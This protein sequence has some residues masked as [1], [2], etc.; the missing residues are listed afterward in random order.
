VARRGLPW[1]TY[2]ILQGLSG[3]GFEA[4]AE[5][6]RARLLD[7]LAAQPA[8]FAHY[9]A[10]SGAGLEAAGT[11]TTAA[12][13]IEALRRGYEEETFALSSGGAPTS[14]EGQ[15]RRMSR[16]SDGVVLAEVAVEGTHELPRTDFSATTEI[17]S[18]DAMTLTFTDP[19]GEVA[20]K[21][22]A[23][24]FPAFDQAEVELERADG[25]VQS[26]SFQAAPVEIS[27]AVDDTVRLKSYHFTGERACGCGAGVGAPLGALALA[28][29]AGN[30][31]AE[32]P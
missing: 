19:T 3:Y 24:S 31:L 1:Q 13:F 16:F 5:T 9:D 17:F 27:A 29:R 23:V 10:F 2:F 15:I 28:I 22:I 30:G 6:L 18:G 20:G 25:S 26:M 32:G 14:R 12:V 7:T 21:Q 8:M 11:T 4:E